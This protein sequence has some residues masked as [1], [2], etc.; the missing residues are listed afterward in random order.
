LREGNQAI[1][2][3]NPSDNTCQTQHFNKLLQHH[4]RPLLQQVRTRPTGP[5]S[6]FAKILAQKKIPAER[7]VYGALNMTAVKHVDFQVRL[8]DAES[9]ATTCNIAD[10]DHIVSYLEREIYGITSNEENRFKK[11]FFIRLMEFEA[12]WQSISIQEL[13]QPIKQRVIHF[14]YPKMHLV[15]HISESR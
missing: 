5:I 2:A 1:G 11:E 12:W 8:S 6:T 9:G 13:Q 3:G 7:E 4:E 14:R 15:S 10:T